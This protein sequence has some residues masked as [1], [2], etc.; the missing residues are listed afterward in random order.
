MNSIKKMMLSGAL[1]CLIS[2]MAY[3]DGS[4][5]QPVKPYWQD[6]QVV[7]VNKEKPRSSF[8]SYADRETALTSRF[9]KSPYYS[10]LNGTWKFFFV[11]SYKDLPQNITDPSVNTSS[12]DDITVP[13][14]WEVQGHGV[15]I[16]T[17]H[18]YEFKPRN[19]QPPLLPE[20]NPVGVYRRDIE[21]PAGW[22]NR[23]IYLHIGG[24][25]SGLYVYLNGKEVGYSEDSKNPAEFLINKYLQ[26]G[27]NVL[28]LKIFRW[29]TGSY[30]ECQDF[31]RMSGIERDVFLWSQPKASIQDFRVVSTLDDTYTNGIFKLAVDLKNHTQETK[32]LNVGYELLDAKGNLVTSEANDIWVSPASPQTASFEY[33]LKNVAPWSAEHQNLYKLLMTIKEE[34]KVIEVVPFNVGFRR[35][36]MKQIDQVAENGKPYTVLLFNGQPVKFKGVN[37]HEH[38]PETGHYVTEEL[39]RKDFELMKQNNINA[40][41]L[42]HYPQDRKFYELCDEYGLYVYDEANIESHGM[43]YSLK[44]GGTLGN[45]P[46][47]LIP[48]M[49]RTMNMYERNKN[50]PSV[51]FWSLGNEAG[52][53]YNFY[54]TYLY[55]KDKEINSMNRPVNY[56]RALWEWNTDMYVPQYPSAEW[57][58]EI[59][60]KGS[61]RPVAPSE[62]SHAMG[63]SSGNLWDQ[64]KAIYKYPNLQGGFIWDWVDQGILEKDKN[65][66]EYYT[67][68]GD[69]GVNAPSDGNFLCNGIVNPDRT[70]HPAMAEVK[71]AHQNIGFEAIDLANGLFR[72]TN[73]FYF[74]NL[75]KYMVHYSVTANN[76]VVRSGKV[77][78]DI[79]PQASKEFTVPIGNLKPQ[80]GTEYFV[81]FNVTT[82]EK[83]PLIPIGHEIACDQFRLPI[84]SPK[85]AFKTSGPKLTVSTNGDNLSASSSK[86]NFMFNKKTGIVTSY[87]V[88][89]TEYFSEGFGIQPNFWRAPT[90]ND[91]GNG[92]PKRLQVWKESSKNFNVTDA[93]VTMDGN[94]AVVNVNYL[95]PAGNLYIV[96]YTIYPSGAV[97]V[98]ARFTS[99]D[100]D[101]AQTEVSESTRTATFTPGRDA[102]RKEA[103]KLNV[104]RIGVRFRLPASMNQVEYFGRGPAENYLDRNAGS[105][106][107]LYKST[108]E[109]LYFPYVR[110]QENGHHTDT[111]WVSLSTGK[112]GLL[113]QADN[114]IGFNA[115]RNSIEDFDDEEA[116]GLS[117]QW[118]NFT[119]EQVANHD[120]AAAKNV[121]RR[122]HHINDITPRDFVEVCVDLKQQGVAGYDSW[123]SRPEPAYTLPANREYNWG[124]TLIPLK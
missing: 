92:M 28:T 113:I 1:G 101:A 32:N 114:T 17:N 109:E 91:Y 98:A 81:N 41:R 88:D 36:E 69:Y 20:A 82:V 119:P 73:R 12:W 27:K 33:D 65:G 3:A 116:T 40:V 122:Q 54:Q 21:I 105:M 94:N 18:G 66:R 90:D 14:N 48:H 10:L 75:K 4:S 117:R 55:L 68:G 2:G 72:V 16:Y 13:G 9:E 44:K 50:Y 102:A 45:N 58:E 15:A 77:S 39:M 79:E 24:A 96:N 106:V 108:A 34:G 118:S 51:T 11:D 60:R 70:P 80:A 35:F 59:G 6:I 67:Y 43:Y 47:W 123:G 22:D 63:N 99:T 83:E 120:E 71:Y 87:K 84:E 26:P 8:M 111:R 64:W 78:L 103:S 76:K 57:L 74:T 100:M 31:W 121:L 89:G 56:E 7:A 37:I 38:N 86:V 97:N 30:L 53:G 112:K 25:K 46:E 62:Y 61:D 104:P 107:G 19:P 110:P 115:L 93:T 124:F 49:D 95:L 5:P 42:C 52:N 29:S 23:D 85:K